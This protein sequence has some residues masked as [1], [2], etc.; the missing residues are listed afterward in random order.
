MEDDPENEIKKTIITH[1][2]GEISSLTA[3]RASWRIR[4]VSLIYVGPFIVL[5]SIF[6]GKQPLDDLKITCP[7]VILFSILMLLWI[8]MGFLAGLN[9]DAINKKCNEWRD[10][11][12]KIAT[13]KIQITE[14]EQR[15]FMHH[16][17]TSIKIQY[18]GVYALQAVILTLS[19]WLI[20]LVF[21]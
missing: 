11:I 17:I 8:A 10:V 5:G 14:L 12:F 13:N 18:L 9:E 4:I 19:I 3:M 20:N 15:S 16:H 1:L 7:E 21:F 2:S 6:F